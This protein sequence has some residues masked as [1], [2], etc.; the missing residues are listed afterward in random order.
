MRRFTFYYNYGS[1]ILYIG[2]THVFPVFFYKILFS[3]FLVLMIDADDTKKITDFR[4][5]AHGFPAHARTLS[6]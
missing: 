6:H 2:L 4:I 3:S 5:D 1:V